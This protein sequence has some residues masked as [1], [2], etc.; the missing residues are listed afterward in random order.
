MVESP[1]WPSTMVTFWWRRCQLRLFYDGSRLGFVGKLWLQLFIS[2][3]KS[4]EDA[5]CCISD[6]T[7]KVLHCQ[8]GP[9]L[10]NSTSW[11]LNCLCIGVR[12][13]WSNTVSEKI[14]ADRKMEKYVLVLFYLIK[15]CTTFQL[16]SRQIYLFI[17]LRGHSHSESSTCCLRSPVLQKYNSCWTC[18]LL[19][20]FI[21]YSLNGMNSLLWAPSSNPL[22]ELFIL[23]YCHCGSNLTSSLSTKSVVIVM[24]HCQSGS[25]CC[26]SVHFSPAEI[27]YLFLSR[28]VGGRE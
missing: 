11:S 22:L 19:S 6:G 27:P 10:W 3:M 24:C 17:F 21:C 8:K 12:L 26:T 25:T 1:Q 13:N 4:S 23:L 18:H 5:P 2:Q 28:M 14:C 15:L 16:S 20:V 9:L 7:L